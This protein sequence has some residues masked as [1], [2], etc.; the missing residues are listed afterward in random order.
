MHWI[1]ILVTWAQFCNQRVL[2]KNISVHVLVDVAC[3]ME[4]TRHVT[5]FYLTAFA[6]FSEK[7]IFYLLYMLI[8]ISSWIFPHDGFTCN[9]MYE[10]FF[11]TDETLIAF[12]KIIL[13]PSYHLIFS[14]FVYSDNYVIIILILND[15]ET[16]RPIMYIAHRINLA[17]CLPAGYS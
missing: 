9:Y 12:W 14:Y 4:V 3:N 1:F 10:Y 13:M 11:I 6:D 15:K 16:K 17:Y 2:T 5:I 8:S 7:Q